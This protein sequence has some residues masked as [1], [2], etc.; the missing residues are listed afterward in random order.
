MRVKN[1][2]DDNKYITFHLF[3]K[4]ILAN[5]RFAPNINSRGNKIA[6]TPPFKA[7]DPVIS[8]QPIIILQKQYAMCVNMNA[9]SRLLVT[10]RITCI[11]FH[12]SIK[13]C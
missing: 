5:K 2:I 6:T 13:R 4:P 11:S 7:I 12:C 3:P 8:C 10:H 1:V 9:I